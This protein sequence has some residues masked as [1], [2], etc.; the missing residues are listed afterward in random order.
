MFAGLVLLR[1]FGC[2]LKTATHLYV[3]LPFLI[4]SRVR[5]VHSIPRLV[6][7]LHMRTTPPAAPALYLPAATPAC[8]WITA[9]GT[10]RLLWSSRT[11]CRRALG[12]NLFILP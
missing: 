3:D 2:G 10:A 5:L 9:T 12:L 6:A 7:T 1:W 8:V 11:P 4:P